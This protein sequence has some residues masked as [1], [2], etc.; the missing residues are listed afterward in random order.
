[1]VELNPIAFAMSLQEAPCESILLIY[2]TKISFFEIKRNMYKILRKT[3]D[4][5]QSRINAQINYKL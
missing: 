4:G 1:M 3:P 2:Q 5:R